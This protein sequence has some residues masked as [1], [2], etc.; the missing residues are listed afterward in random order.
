MKEFSPSERV[1]VVAIDQRK[2]TPRYE[3]EFL[4]GEKAGTVENVPAGRLRGAWS[5]V[6][7]YDEYMAHWQRF[8]SEEPLD[9][10]EDGAIECVFLEVVPGSVAELGW[11]HSRWT[12]I[13]KDRAALAALIG[14][15]VGEVLDQLDYFE[16]QGAVV[17]SPDGTMR[18]AAAIAH[19]NPMLILDWVVGDERKYQ[20][21]CKR[22]EMGTD[23]SGHGYRT[24][25][26]AE[27]DSYLRYGRPLHELLRAWCGHRAVTLQER[28][29]AAEAEV[30]RLDELLARVLD[31]LKAHDHSFVAEIIEQEHVEGRITPATVRP[32]VDRPLKPSEIPVIHVPVRRGRW[33]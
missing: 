17:V 19:A 9:H 5:G 20:E 15:T 33:W 16:D 14:V 6:E 13:V 21:L 25:P 22:G 30:R 11:R 12:A 31:E 27:Y 26:E 1:R 32:V 24:S 10:T 7:G 29:D 8:L 4:D 18:L 28:I 2:K 3:V 23:R